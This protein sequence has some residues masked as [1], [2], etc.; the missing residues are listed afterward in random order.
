M[1]N[2]KVFPLLAS[3]FERHI[4]IYDFFPKILTGISL[5]DENYLRTVHLL[6]TVASR[7]FRVKFDE[8]FNPS[9]LQ[10]VLYQNRLKKIEPLMKKRVLTNHQWH[11]LYPDS[12]EHT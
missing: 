5:E 9:M 8:E 10:A 11:L 2:R 7:A 6:R 1:T 12:G 3:S 4:E